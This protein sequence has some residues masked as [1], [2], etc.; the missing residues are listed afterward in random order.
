VII[1][2]TLAVIAVVGLAIAVVPGAAAQGERVPDSAVVNGVPQGIFVGRS[3][4]TGRAVCLLFLSS[5]RISRAIPEGG[6]E[7]FDW[8][9][10]KAA[11]AGDSGTWQMRGDQ[12]VVAWGDGGVNQGPITV[13]P[14]GIEFYGKRYAK[15]VPVGLAA[16]VGRWEAARGTA[17]VGGA[18]VN[19]VSELVIQADGRYQ[20]G[21]TTGGV[22]SGRAV[23]SDRSMSGKVSVN[24]LTIIFTSDAGRA[25]SHTF[26]P[27]AGTPV[28]AFSAD[29]DMF[30]RTGPAPAS[31]PA[32]A[33]R[34]AAPAPSATGR[35]PAASYQGL[36][37]TTP[38]GWTSGLQQGH[39]LLTP[40][41]ATPE[42]VVIVVLSGAERLNGKSFDEWLRAK[43]AADLNGGLRALQ[44]A[45]PTRGKSGSL[46][47]LST[48]RTVQAQ[49]GGV[50]LQIYYA[51]SD[52]QQ[53]GAGMAAAA[54]E[55]AMKTHIAGVQAIFHSLNFGNGVD[56]TAV[57]G[58]GPSPR[59]S[60]GTPAGIT[61]IASSDLIGHW[62]HS[63]SS[64]FVASSGEAK[65]GYGQGYTFSPDGTYTY[66]FTGMIDRVHFNESDSGTWALQNGMLVVRSRER[67]RTKTYQIVQFQTV[68]D[69][70][71]D[72]TLLLA[73]Y[74]VTASNINAWG[75]KYLRKGK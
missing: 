35:S 10:H 59:A 20:W 38:A 37:F 14:D 17:I 3:L 34:L 42:S 40:T 24:G 74:P 30:T 15:P 44:S 48:G 2:H 51:I 12:L 66:A 57:S 41:N 45:P 5:G 50:L 16:I 1:R 56:S 22:V 64:R 4:L 36:S 47:V 6:L 19:Q 73:D 8:L 21:A 33:D 75:E 60:P 11:H 32:P 68:A 39:F 26:L 55:A 61:K 13:R 31:V 52:G 28:T 9:R 67:A 54:S 65:K 72:M 49:S 43:M 70:G 58:V 62:D 7:Q 25:T 46:D 53:T 23:A 63:S 29:A 18:G 71:T 69:G 27:V